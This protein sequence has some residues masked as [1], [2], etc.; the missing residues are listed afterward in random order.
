VGIPTPRYSNLKDNNTRLIDANGRA[1]DSRVNDPHTHGI[2]SEKKFQFIRQWGG[3]AHTAADWNADEQAKRT[4]RRPVALGYW[5]LVSLPSL[6][7][8]GS[9]TNGEA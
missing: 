6:K 9:R 5:W 7:K 2:L 1:F 3:G 8:T 4:P